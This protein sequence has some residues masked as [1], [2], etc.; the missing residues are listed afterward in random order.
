[1]KLT[2][3]RALFLVEHLDLAAATQV[4]DAKWE[5]FQLAHLNDD[6]TFRIEVKSRQIAWSWLSAVE[7]LADAILGAQS[8]IFVSINQ[9]E[10]QEKIRYAKRAIEALTPSVQPRL[11]RDSLSEIQL[12]NGARLISLAA[13]PPRGKARMNVYLDEYAHVRDDR[14][15]YTGALPVISKGKGRLRIGSSPLGASGVFWEVYKQ[16]LRPYPGY[17]R[18]ATPWWVVQAFC[19]NVVEAKRL[20]PALPT[21]QRVEMFGNDRI[22]A[23]YANLPEED[24]IQEYECGFV[25]ESTAWITWEE[26][27]A[28]EDSQLR[29]LNTTSK[30]GNVSAAY[31][32]IDAT[33]QAIRLGQIESVLGGGMDIGRT[34]NTTEIFLVGVSTLQSYPLRLTLSLDGVD[35]DDQL[36]VASY[37][38]K[39]LPISKLLIDKNGM[40]MN[41]AENLGKAFPTKALGVDFT[42]P[43]KTLWATDAKM[44]IQQRKTPLPADRDLAYQIHSIKKTVTAAKNLVFDT[45]RNEKHHADKFWAWALALHAATNPPVWTTPPQSHSMSTW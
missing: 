38:L 6:S 22:K 32:A 1:V 4:D 18:K 29:W 44:L 28:V 2:T 37:A 42:G 30:G 23:I 43:S 8:S 14:P 17:K 27:K 25:D 31:A 10:A 3:L 16:E 7:G 41:L 20:A 19:T 36:A 11:T 21:A 34:R 39:K 35:F 13:R 40:G 12:E 24:F 5:H 26:I 45:A 15:I 9:D 33:A